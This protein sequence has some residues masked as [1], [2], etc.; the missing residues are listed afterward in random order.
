MYLHP[1][2]VGCSHF[3]YI[4]FGPITI[5]YSINTVTNHRKCSSYEEFNL[6][7][8]QGKVQDVT[9]LVFDAPSIIF[10]YL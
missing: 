4:S 3:F 6:W 9:H 1:T 8:R 5:F 10:D 2:T 7:Q